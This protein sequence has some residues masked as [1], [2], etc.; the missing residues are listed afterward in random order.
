MKT[1]YNE[2]SKNS[3][4][5]KDRG[6]KFIHLS[7]LHIGKRV[8]EFSMIEDQKYILEKILRMVKMEEADAVI[9]AGDV[10]DRPVPSA[11]AVQVLDSFLTELS[12]LGVKV[13]MTS[14]NHDSAE[15]LAFGSKLMEGQNVFIS[16]VYD[17][18]IQ[19]IVLEDA[20]GVVNIYLMPFLKPAMVRQALE[21]LGEEDLKIESYQD[22]IFEVIERMGVNENERNLLVAHQFVT[23]ASCCDSE[24][25]QVGGVDQIGVELFDAFDYVA[26]GHIH[27]P[28]NI[29]R[30][31]VRYCGTP[32]KYSFSEAD[33]TKSVT[34]VE[35][36]EKGNVNLRTIPL[37]P[38][39]DMR[40]IKGTY[41]EVTSSPYY[42]KELSEDYVQVTLT[43]EDDV[44][45]VLQKLR[46]FYPNLMHLEYDNL[47]TRENQ[48]LLITEETE[49]KSEWEVLCEFYQLQNNQEM[50]EEQRAF[51]QKLI[52][53]LL[54][55]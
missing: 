14:G 35:M 18:V 49:K 47:R 25:V 11:E 36:E 41:V 39:R 15:R 9:I 24:D 31:T 4:L 34:I 7:D 26:L 2:L 12:K 37:K 13:F 3:V 21:L 52:E 27:S 55:M 45:D 38:L 46:Y 32:L 16:P 28:Q 54:G 5:R 8:H 33:Q 53:K 23:G 10:Y 30:E 40:K 29:S 44:V 20:H 17:G 19:K 1:C 22:A 50:D 42:K 48:E 43:D 6:M 51:S